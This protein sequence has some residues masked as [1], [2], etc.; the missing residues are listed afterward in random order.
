MATLSFKFLELLD[1]NRYHQ[2]IKTF[3]TPLYSSHKRILSICIHRPKS[4]HCLVRL[5]SKDLRTHTLKTSSARQNLQSMTM[6]AAHLQQIFAHSP[7]L[8]I[9]SLLKSHL[10][11]RILNSTNKWPVQA[12]AQKVRTVKKNLIHINQRY[13]TH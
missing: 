7:Q 2:I 1:S 8:S 9:L 12:A 6:K 3:K 10:I 5:W 13:A 11:L 4:N